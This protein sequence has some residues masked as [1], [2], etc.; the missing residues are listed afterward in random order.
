VR[1][2][3]RRA[4]RRARARNCSR[5]AVAL[6]RALAGA[7]RARPRKGAEESSWQLQ[8][9]AGGATAC[10][11]PAR[12][13]GKQGSSASRSLGSMQHRSSQIV[14]SRACA[15]TNCLRQTWSS[16]HFSEGGSCHEWLRKTCGATRADAQRVGTERA[17][18]GRSDAPRRRAPR[19]PTS[20]RRKRQSS[21][22][23]AVLMFARARPDRRDP[24]PPAP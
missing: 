14:G 4:D 8:R 1:H 10:D 22:C 20:A 23:P 6:D 18:G 21:R 7:P 13:T 3:C 17:I 12:Y 19:L 2:Q 9:N 15:A 16:R 24:P 11:L 5:T